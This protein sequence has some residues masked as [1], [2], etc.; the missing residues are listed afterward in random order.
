MNISNK[1]LNFSELSNAILWF[2][3]VSVCAITYANLQN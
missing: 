2:A 1:N 3:S